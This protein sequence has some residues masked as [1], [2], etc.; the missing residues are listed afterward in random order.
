MKYILKTL[1]STNER[2]ILMTRELIKS[3]KSWFLKWDYT[4]MDNQNLLRI[5]FNC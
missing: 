2:T 4:S 1:S 3:K 5:K